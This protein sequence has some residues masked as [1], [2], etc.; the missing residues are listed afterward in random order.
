MAS[1]SDKSADK[2][3][4]ADED[5]ARKKK[6]FDDFRDLAQEARKQSETDRDYYDSA[7][8]DASQLNDTQRAVLKDRGQPAIILNR[9]AAAIN[10]ILGVAVQ[11][12]TDPRALMRNPP[13][14]KRPGFASQMM[15]GAA[16]DPMAQQEPSL[17]AGDV[18]TM[19][20][21]Y[22]A[23]CSRFQEIKLDVLEN[24]AIE[25]CAAVEIGGDKN[26]KI[27][28]TRIR[29]DEFFYDPRSREADFSDARYMGSAKWMYADEV[30]KFASDETVNVDDAFGANGD[31][32]G[33][34]DRSWLDQPEDSA[35]KPAWADSKTRRLMVVKMWYREGGEWYRCMF[36]AGGIIKTEKSPYVDDEGKTICGIEAQSA[37]VDRKNRRYGLVRNMRGPQ[38]EIN[39]RRI[40]AV[41]EINT[42]QIQQ[43]DPNAPPVDVNEARKEAARP[44]GV[45]PSG[46][47][48]VPRQ[49]VVANNVE[50]MNAAIHE[51][52]RMGPAPAILARGDSSASGRAKQVDQQAGLTELARF[53]G[54][55]TDWQTRVYKQFWARARQFWDAPKWIRVTDDDGAPK[56]VQVNE[57]GEMDPMTGQSTI[58]N[59]V[60][61][62]DVD[63]V[64]DSVPD[65]AT[66][67]QEIFNEI[68]QLVPA[69][70]G[71]PQMPPLTT[72]IRMSPLPK[73]LEIIKQ[74][75]GD[76]A[77]QAQAAAPAQ[78]LEMADK[79]ADIGK[80]Q[81]ET[82]LTEVKTVTEAMRG[83]ME[84]H[85]AQVMPP[86]VEAV[87]NLPQNQPQPPPGQGA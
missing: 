4:S 2:K 44:D 15:G 53:L 49:D 20:L 59:H 78:N 29:W 60:A 50:M 63:V 39:M 67:Q 22:I 55:F 25:G 51:I 66:L 42:R 38:D 21:R 83:H 81:A 6:M 54:R 26:G 77:K 80:K 27:P 7:F 14:D 35:R 74:L 62:M 12:K 70:Q 18:A 32:S 73:R 48:V 13:Q 5:L 82:K 24:L 1:A 61:K 41:H 43:V 46:Y 31:V 3:K 8:A 47:Q 71:T 86:G 30:S 75:E 72:I 23:D 33:A 58:K 45:L 68:L 10:G 40:K 56:Y 11:G 79:Q 57:P 16:P 85:A 37:Y 36:H 76:Q 69:Y 65:T 17:D 87:A 34:A 28:T 84:A 52:E 64:V 19:A 9:T